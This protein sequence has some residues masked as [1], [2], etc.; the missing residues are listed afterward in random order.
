M[1][2]IINDLAVFISG[3]ENLKSIIFVHGFPYDHQM[4]QPQIEELKKDYFCV[5]YDIRGLGESPANDGQFTMESFVDDLERIVDE[6]KLYKPVLCGLSMGGYISLRAM[7]R[8][9]NKF[10][11]L[12]LCDT[13]SE[14][15]NNEG[16]LKRASAIKQI[17][18]GMFGEFV[19][20]FVLNCFGEKFVRENNAEYRK[21]VDRSKKNSPNG[22]KGCLL[23]MAGRTDTTE[24]LKNIKLPALIICGSEDK[25]S[26]P[27]VMKSMSD[28]IPNAKFVI[29]KEAGH[30]TPIEKPSEVGK[31]IKEFL[32]ENN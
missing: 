21:V 23:A 15:D 32:L 11:A 8:I 5:S 14:A 12:I 19:E 9:Q 6:L 31:A 13:K 29:I 25:L 30:M 4:W 2:K 10:S 24:N 1:K 7:E 16:K 26:P 28:K 20:T 22:V 17:N 18:S 3:E 27:S